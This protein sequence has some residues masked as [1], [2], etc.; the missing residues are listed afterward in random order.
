MS[1][2]L[3]Y[4][5]KLAF[6]V[7]T[8]LARLGLQSANAHS[9]PFIAGQQSCHG[10]D[11]C[12]C[13]LHESC[14]HQV[15]NCRGQRG[16]PILE[17]QDCQGARQRAETVGMPLAYPHNQAPQHPDADLPF[18]TEVLHAYDQHVEAI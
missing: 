18:M 3:H 12:Q 2:A 17:P 5:F 7:Q 16:I 15:R 11:Y 1:N 8:L 9:C 14:R 4:N 10:R 13:R 6:H